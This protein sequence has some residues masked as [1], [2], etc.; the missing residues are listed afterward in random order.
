MVEILTFIQLIIYLNQQ[1]TET[2]WNAPDIAEWA[3]TREVLAQAAQGH[4]GC[5]Q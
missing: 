1:S 5:E 3:M 2:A 4:Q